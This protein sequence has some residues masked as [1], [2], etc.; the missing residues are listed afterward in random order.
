[1]V[2]VDDFGEVVGPVSSAIRIVLARPAWGR[3]AARQHGC[4]WREQV[5][6]VR[7]RRQAPRL[8]VDVPAARR[9]GAALDQLQQAV[10]RA[11][12]PAAVGLE[13]DRRAGPADAGVD[14]AEKRRP[15][16]KPLGIGREQIGRCLGIAGR[17]IGEEVDD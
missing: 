9:C 1:M 14:H 8:K 11:D 15:R 16:R 10:A 5:A 3:L 4:D 13:N 2:D 6:A 7:A 12:V 17:R